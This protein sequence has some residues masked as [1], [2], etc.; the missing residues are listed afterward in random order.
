MNGGG[1][2]LEKKKKKFF[3]SRSSDMEKLVHALLLE[4][5]QL[6]FF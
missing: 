1:H 2:F 4:H 3:S 6:Q 5:Y